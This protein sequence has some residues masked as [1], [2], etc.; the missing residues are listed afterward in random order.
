MCT[1]NGLTDVEA[2]DSIYNVDRA[3]GLK[4]KQQAVCVDVDNLSV[5]GDV[6][7]LGSVTKEMCGSCTDRSARKHL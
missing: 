4:H 1:G 2:S 6:P 5:Q 7:T 3:A